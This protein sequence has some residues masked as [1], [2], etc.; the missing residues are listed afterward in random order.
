MSYA[1]AKAGVI[2]FTQA[3]ALELA[4][5]NIN[6]NCVCPGVIYTPLWAENA[7]RSAELNPEASGMSPREFFDKFVVPRVPLKRGQT[8][9]DIG[10]A[11]V[12]FVSEDAVNITG[13]SLN[14]NGGSHMD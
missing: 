9:E 13:Q 4:E 14:V 12:F 3:L 6:V 8:P 7:K 11:V 2:R 10:R 1:V 5:Y